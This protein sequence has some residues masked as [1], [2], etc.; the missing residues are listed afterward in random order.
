MPNREMKEIM[1]VGSSLQDLRDFPEVPRK[2]AG[3]QLELLQ[4]GEEPD[5]FKPM[6]SVGKG[7]QE[8]RIACDDGAFRVFYVVN[9]PE[10]IYVLH[11]FR[12]TTQKTEK[13]DLDLGR[14][15]YKSLG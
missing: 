8:I 9:R 11:A 7:V 15:R 12:K 1:W 6:K 14:T 5:D 4:E 10:A 2:R 3:F 13:R